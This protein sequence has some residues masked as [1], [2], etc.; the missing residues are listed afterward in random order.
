MKSHNDKYLLNTAYAGTLSKLDHTNRTNR[1]R[2]G[3]YRAGKVRQPSWRHNE[4]YDIMLMV[5]AGKITPA[6][7]RQ[8]RAL[9]QAREPR[10]A[11][12]GAADTYAERLAK[13]GATGTQYD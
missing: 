1:E 13:Y 11:V 2:R 3:K 9:Q 8:V 5:N 6:Q 10:Q 4:G 7:A 12:Q